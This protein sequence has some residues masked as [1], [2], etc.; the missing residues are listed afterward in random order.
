[1]KKTVHSIMLE[2]GQ[3]TFSAAHFVLF[4]PHSVNGDLP[5]SVSIEPLHGHNFVVRVEVTGPLDSEN[6]VIDFLVAQGILRV[7]LDRFEQKVLLPARS[8]YVECRPNG[9]D[10]EVWVKCGKA[11]PHRRW[12]FPKNETVQLD[13]SNVTAE[14]IAGVIA[15]DLWNRFKEY[16][17]FSFPPNQYS[18]RLSIEESHG[19][20]GTV[21]ISEE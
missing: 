6:Y 4:I 19:M 10:L 13:V 16:E 8:N 1:M 11:E 15:H 18:I 3:F 20:L 12:V 14:A 2:S 5:S 21:E 17:V 7:I 9:K